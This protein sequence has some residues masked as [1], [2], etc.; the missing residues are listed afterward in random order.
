[1]ATHPH[2]QAAG[3]T[4][5]DALGATSGSMSYPGTG[6]GDRITNTVVSECET[7]VHFEF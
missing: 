3:V 6:T 7:K 4:E 1:M 5:P 2:K